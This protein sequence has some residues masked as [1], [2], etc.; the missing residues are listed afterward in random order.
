EEASQEL[1]AAALWYES[2]QPGLGHRFKTEV[3][4]VLLNIAA[5]PLLQRERDGG[6]RRINCPVFPYY[7]PYFIRRDRIIVVAVAHEHRK[8]G[9]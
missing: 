9:Y 2:K 4:S 6:Y 7:L 8:P 5:N 1:V 3:E